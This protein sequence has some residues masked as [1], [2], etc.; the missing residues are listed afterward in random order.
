MTV[1][2][3]AAAQPAQPPA[4]ADARTPSRT[5]RRSSAGAKTSSELRSLILVPLQ[6]S[7]V[8]AAGLREHVTEAHAQG[9]G[10]SPGEGPLAANCDPGTALPSRRPGPRGRTAPGRRQR[11]PRR[12][13]RGDIRRGRLPRPPQRP[14][15]GSGREPRRPPS[16]AR[17]D[18]AARGASRDLPR[19]RF[20]GGR[21]QP[22]PSIGPRRRWQRS[23]SGGRLSRTRDTRWGCRT[24]L[25][26]HRRSLR[27]C[28][29]PGRGE[30]SAPPFDALGARARSPSPQRQGRAPATPS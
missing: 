1:A 5:A 12:A 13:E 14:G 10:P 24:R 29:P 19:G 25:A 2:P 3:C 27:C 22:S 8:D 6:P 17:G 26:S 11:P 21:D 15:E 18:H 20:D 4:G 23:A 7:E 30:F 16:V 9:V 28:L